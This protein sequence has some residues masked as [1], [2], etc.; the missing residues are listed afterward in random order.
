ME[1]LGYVLLY[2][3][4]GSLPWLCIRCESGKE[5]NAILEIK[6]NQGEKC[7]LFNDVP[8]EFKKYFELLRSD[9]KL[10]YKRLRRLFQGLFYRQH[11]Q[12]DK[13]FDW[14]QLLYLEKLEAE[15]ESD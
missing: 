7:T 5:G 4:K 12:Y 1:S 10:D 14:T 8:V 9:K 13:V 11:F 2:F 6:Q 3:L 15:Q